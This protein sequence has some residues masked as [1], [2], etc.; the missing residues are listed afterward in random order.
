MI[1]LI[2]KKSSCGEIFINKARQHLAR[3]E[4][5]LARISIEQGLSKGGLDDWGEG[6]RLLDEISRCLTGCPEEAI[7]AAEQAE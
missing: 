2:A 3:H 4:W 7:S 1:D 6:Q 5:G